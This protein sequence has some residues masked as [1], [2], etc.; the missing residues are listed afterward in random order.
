MTRITLQ[1][2]AFNLPTEDGEEHGRLH[3]P[4]G[5]LGSKVPEITAG[6]W[7]LKLLT[8]AMGEAASDYLLGALSYLGL[9]IG[10]VG[11]TVTVWLQFRT[12]RYQPVPYWAAVS[13]VAVAG[14]MAADMI[15]GE[16]GVPLTM[17]A[18]V[19]AGALALTFIVWR[20][21]EGTLSI[22]SITTRRREVFY[23]LTVSFTF[24]L[25]TAAGDLTADQLGLG[26]LGSIALFAAAMAAVALGCWRFHLNGVAGFWFAYIL[27]RP[28]GAS[29][30]DW[31]SK[32][33]THGGVGF[34]DGPL[35]AAL[36][37]AIVVA[38]AGAFVRRVTTSRTPLAAV[39]QTECPA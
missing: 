3:S 35:A 32:P 4:R 20:R 2:S 13:M 16:L 36:L 1:D 28:L 12:R 15:H 38:V 9:G 17:S 5:G 29:V 34:G 19:C 8:T 6:F 26:F 14:T 22:H 23:W 11:F 21:T 7:G 30:A 31:L 18:L 24:A 25:G 39:D 27:T 33:A 37:T 10:I